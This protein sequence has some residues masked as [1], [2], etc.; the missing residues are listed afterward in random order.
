M[1]E[2]CGMERTA[3]GLE[4]ALGE[5]AALHDEFRKD[6]RVLGGDERSTSRW[7]RRAG[8]TTSSSW[9]S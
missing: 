4:K 5:I 9:R 6:V 8:S 7:R 3:E 2:H 1:W